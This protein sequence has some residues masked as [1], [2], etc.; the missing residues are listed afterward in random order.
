[1]R[2]SSHV[3]RSTGFQYKRPGG[4]SSVSIETWLRPAR[5]GNTG[6]IQGRERIFSALHIIQTAPE[7]TQ[8]HLLGLPGNPPLVVKHPSI[9]ATHLAAFNA[10]TKMLEAVPPFPHTSSWRDPWTQDV[11]IRTDWKHSNKNSVLLNAFVVL[12]YRIK[13]VLLWIYFAVSTVIFYSRGSI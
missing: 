1:M 7:P 13:S 3:Y 12:F 9:Q 4:V 6:S 8:P 2:L 5:P 10:E 11:R